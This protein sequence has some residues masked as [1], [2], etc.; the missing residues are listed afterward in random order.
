MDRI[1]EIKYLSVII[2]IFI[3]ACIETDIYLPAFPDMMKAFSVSESA[4]QGLLTW[5]FVGIC[6]S[7]PFYGPISDSFGRKKPLL[8]RW[9]CS[10]WGVY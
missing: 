4:I 3:A 5:N 10:S 6:I 1:K 9:L 2:I 7:G 8:V